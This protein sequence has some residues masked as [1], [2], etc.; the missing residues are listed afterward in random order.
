MARSRLECINIQ[1]D[2][3]YWGKNNSLEPKPKLNFIYF[4]ISR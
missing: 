1:N 3:Q 2:S 4:N